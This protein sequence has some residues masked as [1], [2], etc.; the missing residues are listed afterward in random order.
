VKDKVGMP[1]GVLDTIVVT[2]IADV[3]SEAPVS[4]FV[5]Y[6]FLLLLVSAK[7]ANLADVC[8]Q[9]ILKNATTKRA[10]AARNYDNFVGKH[11]LSPVSLVVDV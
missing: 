10:G 7:D 11:L 3:C 2:H 6:F 1:K 4:E 9:D 5:P 8:I